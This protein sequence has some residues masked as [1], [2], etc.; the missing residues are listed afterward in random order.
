MTSRMDRYSRNSTPPSLQ[1]VGKHLM[2]GHLALQMQQQAMD[3]TCLMPSLLRASSLRA[4]P[5]DSSPF[6]LPMNSQNKQYGQE[7]PYESHQPHQPHAAQTSQQLHKQNH[8]DLKYSDKSTNVGMAKQPV[9]TSSSSLL[10]SIPMQ[11][12]NMFSLPPTSF[13]N[14]T[15]N[16]EHSL[17]SSF[18]KSFDY[19]QALQNLMPHQFLQQQLQQRHHPQQLLQRQQLQFKQNQLQAHSNN[20]KMLNSSIRQHLQQPQ[21]LYSANQQTIYREETKFYNNQPQQIETFRKKVG[22]PR[23]SEEMK[24]R[25]KNNKL[26]LKKQEIKMRHQLKPY[27][28]QNLSTCSSKMLVDVP[29]KQLLHNQPRDYLIQNQ[30]EKYKTP[31]KYEKMSSRNKLLSIAKKRIVSGKFGVLNCLKLYRKC[32]KD[33]KLKKFFQTNS[34]APSMPATNAN[35]QIPVYQ[36]NFNRVYKT[37][38][39]FDP[40]KTSKS[41]KHISSQTSLQKKMY[42]FKMIS[43][44][45]SNNADYFNT[46]DAKYQ[47][48]V[49]NNKKL[50]CD[51]QTRDVNIPKTSAHTN[52]SGTMNSHDDTNSS[53][54]SEQSQVIE[55]KPNVIPQFF[56]AGSAAVV[57][58]GS[59]KNKTFE[60]TNASLPAKKRKWLHVE[61][62]EKP[63]LHST[64]CNS[65]VRNGTTNNNINRSIGNDIKNSNN[66]NADFKKAKNEINQASM[67]RITRL[68]R[69]NVWNCLKLMATAV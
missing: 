36:K 51:V 30:Q 17:N 55:P 57:E 11:H 44:G 64:G 19:R 56:N 2:N 21:T 48:F 45:Y 20:F 34:S 14:R 69:M 62:T 22:R 60:M 59:P 61:T 35:N 15:G 8:K 42:P 37:L 67:Y 32:K 43:P 16:I 58:D 49:T 63:L 47:K 1:Y 66:N 54:K 27:S 52:K 3:P 25:N 65:A 50:N 4:A 33:L 5:K 68:A 6:C 10:S 41:G 39:N 24:L 13:S 18:K 7:R 9:L 31:K 12:N 29:G 46:N 26:K 40:T 28:P 53:K 38:V 23:L